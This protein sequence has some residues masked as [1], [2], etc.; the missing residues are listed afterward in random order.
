MQDRARPAGRMNL[1]LPQRARRGLATLALALSASAAGAVTVTISGGT[2]DEDLQQSLRQ[3]SGLFGLEQE[4]DAT[5]QDYVAAARADYRRLLT[6]LYSEGYYGGTISILVDGREA[7]GISPVGGPGQVSAITIRVEP[8]PR[9]D[10][11]RAEV[12]PVPPETELPDSF[13]PGEPARSG[14]VR[15]A[16]RSAVNSWRDLGYAKA[17]PA[18]QDIEADHANSR[19]NVG[20]RI[21]PGPLLTF[22]PLGVEGNTRVRT[23]R[24]VEIAG[25]PTGER[26]DPDEVDRATQRL[27]RTQVFSSATLREADEIGPNDTLPFTAVVAEHPPRRFGFGL[28]VSSIEGL[29]VS[30][31]WLHRNLFGGAE[32]L[33]VE[34]EV[35]GISGNTDGLDYHLEAGFH[36]PATFGPDNEF[37][38]TAEFA[39]AVDPQIDLTALEVETGFTRFQSDR[40]TLSGGIG[41]RRASVET[42]AASLTYTLALLPLTVEYDRRDNE[43][44]AHEGFYVSSEV[45]PFFGISEAESGGRIMADARVYKSFLT[46]DRLTLAGRLQ[47]GSVLGPDAPEAPADFLF[48][49]GGGGSV[50][51]QDYQSLGVDFGGETIGGTSFLGAQVEAR[52]GVTDKIGAV[53]FYDFGMVGDGPY[54]EEDDPSHAGAGLGV[55]YDTGIGPI[56]LDLATPVSGDEAYESVSVYIGIGQAF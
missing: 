41:L 31:F 5:A 8:G 38:V 43:L 47:Y 50:R 52:F 7:A 18:G 49:S 36:R 14:V 37:Y 12:G 53:A 10:F 11:G 35:N 27:R 24:V 51:G 40:L 42:A 20:V 1:R 13:A 26:F 16:A 22:G 44:D 17:E 4:E 33:R 25:L 48:H 15:D 2:A 29:T 46:D 23:T 45:T 34:G 28:E 9:F 21:A 56:R 30:A 6:A 55:R 54:P 3:A 32:R 19:L 39:E